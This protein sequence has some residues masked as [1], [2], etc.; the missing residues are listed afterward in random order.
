M[1]LKLSDIPELPAEPHPYHLL[2]LEHVALDGGPSQPLRRAGPAD[3]PAV[4]LLPGLWTTGYTFRN[5]IDRLADRARLVLCEPPDG[6]DGAA[7][8]GPDG[9]RPQDLARRI[10]ALL[11]AL[12]ADRA[13]LVGCAEAGLGVLELALAAPERLRAA[14]CLGTALRL[15]RAVRLRGWWR[16][17]G[18]AWA[19]AA[20]AQPQ[21]AALDMLAYA[22]PAVISRQELRELARGWTT[23]PAAR[24]RARLLAASL[25]SDYRAP[26]RERLEARAASGAGLGVELK[27]V[28]G[29]RD[30]SAPP[31][32]GRWLTS[33]F[34][35]AELL[36]AEGS[37]GAVQVEEPE[38]T[39]AIIARAAG[40]QPAE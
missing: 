7:A 11:D 40:L 39:A 28:Y 22:D 35:G 25:C 19:K 5:L 33:R 30:R 4:V 1:N 14:V 18:E 20:F 6:L 27:L 37:S 12:A 38:W 2:P 36:V 17:R 10:G 26:T 9:L 32:Q 16:G 21:R 13:V 31:E 8:A 23:W 15:P 3:G 34:P 24:R 29:D